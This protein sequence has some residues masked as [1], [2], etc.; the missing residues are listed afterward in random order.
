MQE[1]RHRHTQTH[2]DT[3]EAEE[4][5]EEE[6]SGVGEWWW[7]LFWESSSQTV[8]A[9]TKSSEPWGFKLRWCVFFF[10]CCGL[11][12]NNNNN[13]NNN[14]KREFYFILQ[15]LQEQKEKKKHKL[16]HWKQKVFNCLVCQLVSLSFA[17]YS[18]LPPSNFFF[19]FFLFLPL[20]LLSMIWETRFFDVSS[21]PGAQIFTRSLFDPHTKNSEWETH[22]S[23]SFFF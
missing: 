3:E 12:C 21:T 15:S 4:E 17:A 16:W 19:F 10:F 8:S 7:L 1:P 18:F 14:K 6:D 13:N 23:F 5:E 11:V 20:L 9:E 22:K 2:T